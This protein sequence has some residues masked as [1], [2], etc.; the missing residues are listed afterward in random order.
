MCDEDQTHIVQVPLWKSP[1]SDQPVFLQLDSER[2]LII[3]KQAK[4]MHESLAAAPAH[5]TPIF[6][7]SVHLQSLSQLDN[8]S[9]VVFEA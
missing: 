7:M 5:A 4:I 9:K 1:S 6:A 2:M 3:T 8:K